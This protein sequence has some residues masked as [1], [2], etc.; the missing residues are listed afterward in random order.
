MDNYDVCPK[1]G[2]KLL[3]GATRCLSCKAVLK[4]EEEQKAMIQQFMEPNKEGFNKKALLK[5]VIYLIVI[6]IIYY[7][8]SEEIMAVINYITGS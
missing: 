5:F 6:G 7:F 1:C 2:Q 3:V 8:Y 4:T